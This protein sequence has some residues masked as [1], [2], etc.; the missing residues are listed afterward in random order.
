[1]T[2]EEKIE[3]GK[4]FWQ[5]MG[6][7]REMNIRKTA[8]TCGLSFGRVWRFIYFSGAPNHPMDFTKWY[9]M[10]YYPKLSLLDQDN[11][12]D[13]REKVLHGA[14][15]LIIEQTEWG[16]SVFVDVEIDG[17]KC[18]KCNSTDLI[19]FKKTFR[20]GQTVY[21]ARCLIC[22]HS[23]GIKSPNKLNQRNAHMHSKWAVEVKKRDGN[24]CAI[25][26]SK[27]SL[28]AH[29]IV[30]VLHDKSLMYSLNN[31]ITLC[32]KHHQLAHHKL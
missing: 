27:E 8:Q 1:M 30:P 3:S 29:H 15:K 24:K 23:H 9:L 28:E 6:K 22:D 7:Y 10:E 18:H 16:G 11:A 20:A 12:K 21:F 19:C 4:P 5:E 17:E 14:K 2:N 26:G 25:C 31:G 13:E 32:K